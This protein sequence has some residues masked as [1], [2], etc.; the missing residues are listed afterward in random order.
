MSP[1]SPPSGLDLLV[2]SHPCVR[3]VNQE[4]YAEL[5]SRGVDLKIVVPSHWKDPYSPDGFSPEALSSLQGQLLP[6]AILG[7]GRQQRHCYLSSPRKILREQRPAV[8]FIEQEPFSVAGLQWAWACVR[9]GIP[10]GVQAAENLD[11]SMP[12]P[13]RKWRHW[14]LARASFVAARS[15]SAVTLA[16]HWGAKGAVEIVAHPVPDWPEIAPIAHPVFTVGLCGR[17]VEAK[18]IRDLVAARDAMESDCDLRFIGDGPLV[19][20]LERQDR[21]SVI[22]GI[23]HRSMAEQ[24]AQLDVVAVPSLSTPTWTEQFGRVIVEAMACGLPV[25]AYRSGE[26]PW[27]IEGSDAG[28]LVDEGDVAGLSAALQSLAN[29]AALRASLGAA[30]RQ[31]VAERYTVKASASALWSLISR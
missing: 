23:D 1:A 14:V 15:Q 13:L 24:Y 4:I 10:F 19:S 26:I 29:D 9:R 6:R 2:V 30:G 18:G 25:V 17:L 3:P 8:V 7:A 28:I 27:V 22:A 20:W 12:W 16:K 21:C 5:K 31:R 11:R